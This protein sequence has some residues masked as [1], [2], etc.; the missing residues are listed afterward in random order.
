MIVL[1]GGRGYVGSAFRAFFEKCSVEYVSISRNEV[2]YTNPT[3]LSALLRDIHPQFL[4]NCAGY[5]GKPNVDACEVHKA[6]CLAGNAVLPGVIRLACESVSL[7]WGH[8]SSGC[9]YTGEVLH[10]R[11]FT[12]KDQPNF[13]FRTNNCSFYSGSKALGEECL[14]GADDV[15]IWRL[16]IPFNNQD[17]SRN[18][19]SKLLRYDR[20]L[21]ATN[22]ISHLDE[23]VS[24]CWQSWQLRIPAGI[25][26]I[27]NT[28]S[29]TTR[30]V[31]AL[32]GE[33]LGVK[34][35]FQFFDSEQQFMEQAA[36]TPRS[37]CVLENE[38][39]RS[40]GI[41]VRDVRDA[42]ISSLKCWQTN[43][44]T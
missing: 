16:R 22:S 6:E 42:I 31:V 44:P 14:E 18:Y 25:Y 39:I 34:K 5:T 23:F 43:S 13:S 20:L 38:K 41:A 36:I 21:D 28:G 32:L 19:L 29:V 15:Y 4:I 3:I 7:P 2:D 17:N 9:I 27:T 11:G 40:T 1:L 37:N 12:E 8:V 33:Y 35:Q 30:E 10:G 26:N 24:C